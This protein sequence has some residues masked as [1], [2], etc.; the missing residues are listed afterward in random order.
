V[1]PRDYVGFNARFQPGPVDVIEVEVRREI[2]AIANLTRHR[3]SLRDRVALSA[4][5]RSSGSR[6]SRWG[7]RNCVKTSYCSLLAPA[8]RGDHVPLKRRLARGGGR[9]SHA[10]D[11]EP[12][13][14]LRRFPTRAGAPGLTGLGSRSYELLDS[15]PADPSTQRVYRSRPPLPELY[16]FGTSGAAKGALLS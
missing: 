10:K 14:L 15:W 6:R 12:A 4:R 16:T 2:G 11:T 5:Y 1:G 13:L 3:G 9:K 7:P 8:L